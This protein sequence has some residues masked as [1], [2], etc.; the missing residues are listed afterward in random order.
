MGGGDTPNG[1]DRSQHSQGQT[2]RK[3][4]KLAD[5]SGLFLAVKPNGSKLWQQK[6][7]F[8]D[9]ERLLSHG[10]YT[11][12]SLAQARV[13][14]DE[15]CSL[16]ANGTDPGVQKRLDQIAAEQSAG[17]TF[18]LMVQDYFETIKERNLAE[19]TM[20]KKRWILLDLA[21]PLHP[22]PISQITSAELPHLL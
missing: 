21:Q 7:R 8:S 6:Y 22:R 20:Q 17:T 2:T 5:G 18:K 13:K 19:A 10:A 1:T 15:A 11:D 3:P 14:R 12:L 4:Y 16:I 9:R